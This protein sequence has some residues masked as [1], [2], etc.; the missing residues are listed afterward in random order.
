MPWKKVPAELTEMLA[1]HL[2]AYPDAVRRPMFG[3]TAYFVNGNMF[4][5]TFEESVLLR[6]GESDRELLLG[7][8]DE[9]SVFEPMKGRPMREYIAL[10]EA[11][12][13]EGEFFEP[14]LER[15]HAFGASL[16]PKLPG[17]PKKAKKQPAAK[18]PAAKKPAAKKATARK[19]SR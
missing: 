4:T 17:A 1:Q 13:H 16:P 10:P 2:T 7:D 15:A 18:K 6:L 8:C 5:G 14:W 19:R 3:C 9:A 12:C 11:L